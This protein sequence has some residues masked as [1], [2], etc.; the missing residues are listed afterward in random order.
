MTQQTYLILIRDGRLA[1][2]AGAA[3]EDQLAADGH[4]GV[5]LVPT[6]RGT[7][8][9][10]GMDPG[11]LRQAS[12]WGG[13][14]PQVVAL[15]EDGLLDMLRSLG[16]AAY[17]GVPADHD[18]RIIQTDGTT[19]T[20]VM[21]LPVTTG[22]DLVDA[23]AAHTPW[24][25]YATPQAAAATR[26]AAAHRHR[27]T[28]SGRRV[29][30]PPGSP[31]A[32]RLA[33][34]GVAVPLITVGLPV[35]AAA[36]STASPQTGA[37]Q[38]ATQAPANPAAAG[39]TAGA[40]VGVTAGLNPANPAAN[41]DAAYA[42]AAG[43]ALG[44][45]SAPQ[46]LTVPVDGP[47]LVGGTAT[48]TNAAANPSPGA[49]PVA[50]T[51]VAAGSA[52]QQPASS[53]AQP[54]STTASVLNWI[55]NLLNAQTTTLSDP[56]GSSSGSSVLTGGPAPTGFFISPCQAG[57]VTFS[58]AN[59]GTNASFTA[60]IGY[61][62]GSQGGPIFYQPASAAE[63]GA[64]FKG[65]YQN[66]NY[67]PASVD[68]TVIFGYQPSSTT[69]ALGYL[70][71]LNTSPGL[72]WE[73][74]VRLTA[75]PGTGFWLNQ[76]GLSS[77]TQAY[78][79]VWGSGGY[80][81][82]FTNPDSNPFNL[83]GWSLNSNNTGFVLPGAFPAYTPGGSLQPI[84]S[85]FNNFFGTQGGKYAGGQWSAQLFYT[86]PYPAWINLTNLLTGFT[87]PDGTFVSPGGVMTPTGDGGYIL[88]SDG[89]VVYVPGPGASAPATTDSS[90]SSS[91]PGWLQTIMNG[92]A[93]FFSGSSGG[94]NSSAPAPPASA[95]AAPAT[96]QDGLQSGGGS[97]G[98]A[99][100]SGGW[101]PPSTDVS[102]VPGAQGTQSGPA[103]SPDGS[104]PAAPSP[105]A[106]PDNAAGVPALGGL[107]G[108]PAP[109]NAPPAS[110]LPAN[111]QPQTQTP[112]APPD[113]T[114]PPAS[115]DVSGVPGAQGTQ[116]GAAASPDGSQPAAAS[117]TA[118]PDNAAGVPAMNGLPGGP[119]PTNAPPAQQ[120]T[121]DPGTQGQ[122]D[123]AAAPAPA[124]VANPAPVV[125][126]VPVTGTSSPI[127]GITGI[128]NPIP[129]IPSPVTTTSVP[130]YTPPTLITYG[131]AGSA[132]GTTG[133]GG[134]DIG[135]PSLPAP[136]VT[137]S[138]PAIS[139]GGDAGSG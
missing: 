107:P 119:A 86:Q 138:V 7:D 1:L 35:A 81:W 62:Y 5:T 44:R 89:A 88:S 105:T 72:G 60:A 90:S 6:R 55:W 94:N 2:S 21:L 30:V 130:T 106:N 134:T 114:A 66:S 42:A 67:M 49:S 57:C 71:G 136:I 53:A 99:G 14:A 9:A 27:G 15:Y 115:T 133:I 93:G 64:M 34:A 33:I 3:L 23:I 48:V 79:S 26:I 96:P 43:A 40:T 12:L 56:T 68:G 85:F 127:G 129:P 22:R 109:A 39:A 77:Y 126:P 108:G 123:P 50:G 73:T 70:T 51:V 135:D 102:G 121:P 11:Y 100:A 118:N 132:G 80:Q 16:L 4:R 18:W 110:T 45:L 75:S 124:A 104:Q 128:P 65:S 92:V 58:N 113:S 111:T 8:F 137:A 28:A 24:H 54:T 46:S 41:S 91:G 97:T 17:V 76:L 20:G 38:P 78:G 103:A 74:T 32:R 101:M 47:G 112:A 125:N 139:F 59:N 37:A 69:P 95:P 19:A 83:S 87:M 120:D 116:S 10:D 31:L 29:P 61:G 82:Q 13:T 98:G 117:P 63:I 25:E 122:N 52:P 36:A 131:D 84:D